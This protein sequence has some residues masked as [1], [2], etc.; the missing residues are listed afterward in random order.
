M[1]FYQAALW[2]SLGS[3]LSCF[4]HQSENIDSLSPSREDI[5]SKTLNHQVFIKIQYTSSNSKRI[6]SWALM[7]SGSTENLMSD[8]DSVQVLNISWQ[9]NQQASRQE[10]Y[11]LGSNTSPDYKI[12]LGQ[13]F[14]RSNCM[15]LEGGLPILLEPNQNKPCKIKDPSHWEWVRLQPKSGLLLLSGKISSKNIEFVVD[16]GSGMTAVPGK[17]LSTHMEFTG[18]KKNILFPFGNRLVHK[19]YYLKFPIQIGNQTYYPPLV[20]DS[21]ELWKENY[22][23]FPTIG[24]DFFKTFRIYIDFGSKILGIHNNENRQRQNNRSD[25]RRGG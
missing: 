24:M 23:Y 25:E 2:L 20:F 9:E 19:T 6:E 1:R 17:E 12:I 7:D 16:T 4:L 15:I 22:E 3:L 21:E 14:F 13:P 18:T 10:F 8:I 11:P 5:E